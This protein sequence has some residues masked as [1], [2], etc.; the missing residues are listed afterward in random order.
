MANVTQKAR[1]ILA[2]ESARA[3]LQEALNNARIDGVSI[4]DLM[5][6]TGMNNYSIAQ[7]M[8]GRKA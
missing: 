4:S 7:F 3:N 1:A 6:I 8:S 2:V 5:E